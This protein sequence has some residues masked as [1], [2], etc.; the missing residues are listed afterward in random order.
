M[1]I[2]DKIRN[3]KVQYDIS[4]EATKESALPSNKVEKY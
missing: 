4:G 1:I 3:E 2:D